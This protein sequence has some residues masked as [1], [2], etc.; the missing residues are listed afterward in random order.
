MAYTP[1]LESLSSCGYSTVHPTLPSCSDPEDPALPDRT[2][3][4][5]AL[6]VRMALI[7]LVEYDSKTVV[8]VMHSYGGLVGSEAIP[9]ELTFESRK[10][11]GLNG[12]VVHLFFF[13]AFILDVGQSVLSVFGESPNHDIRPSASGVCTSC[14]GSL[15][16][17]NTDT[18]QSGG[19][20]YLKGGAK[21]LYN[22]LSESEALLWES[23]MLPQSHGVEQTRFTRAAYKYIPSTYLVCENDQAV[24][25]QFQESF[26]KMA[27]ARIERCSAGHCSMLSQTEMLAGKIAEAVEEIAS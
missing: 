27:S 1:L 23:R 26:A 19:I 14:T 13:S 9:E 24:P 11:K 7:R 22:D 10:K 18:I 4:D 5:D 8:V 2:L 6:A 16:S 25:V 17:E 21:L 20:F 3:I 15:P 12:G